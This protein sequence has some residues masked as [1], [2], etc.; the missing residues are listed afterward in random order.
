MARRQEAKDR[1]LERQRRAAAA[2]AA[3]EAK[4]KAAAA[5]GEGDSAVNTAGNDDSAEDDEKYYTI[6]DGG[7]SS[8]EEKGE[9]KSKPAATDGSNGSNA[10]TTKADND[11]KTEGKEDED[12]KPPPPAAPPP[13]EKEKRKIQLRSA[14]DLGN[15]DIYSYHRGRA[16]DE[17]RCPK[18][19]ELLCDTDPLDTNH[20][21]IPPRTTVARIVVRFPLE[22]D[23]D[24]SEDEYV[25]SD[26]EEQQ[27][28]AS[29]GGGAAGGGKSPPPAGSRGKV[30]PNRTLDR[31]DSVGSGGGG[32]RTSRS[33]ASR[34]GAPANPTGGK[35]RR[36]QGGTQQP[37][38]LLPSRNPVPNFVQ[39]I[40]WDLSSPATPAP[41]EYAAR[42]ACE[43]GLSF[44]QTMDLKESIEAFVRSQPQFYAPLI[45]KDPYGT[46]RPDSQYGPPESHCGPV[47]N[48]AAAPVTK[49]VRRGGGGGSS[50]G[51][52]GG[53]LHASG[54]QRKPG[55]VKPDRRGIHVVSPSEVPKAASDVYSAEVCRRAR[56]ASCTIVADRVA[57]NEAT[58]DIVSNEV[59]HICHNRKASG[60]T[61]HCGRH[62]YCDFH[63]AT[64]LSFRVSDYDKKNPLNLPIDYCPVCTLHCTCAKCTRRLEGVAKKLKDTC[65]VQNVGVE[66]VVMDDLFT[67]CSSKLAGGGG[68]G[69][70]SSRKKGSSKKEGSGKKEGSTKKV[71]IDESAS[72][73][74]AAGGAG[75]KGGGSAKRSRLEAEGKDED[76]L[77]PS[78]RSMRSSPSA[79][80]VSSASATASASEPRPKKKR[81]AE[82]Q[83]P[84]VQVLKV[85]PSEFPKE[86]HGTM[87]LDPSSPGDLNQVFTPDGSFP[88]D[89]TAA[90]RVG[91]E[92]EQKKKYQN[93]IPVPAA[94][95][96]FFKCSIC[97]KEKGD[98]WVA[99]MKCPRSY[100][101]KC[102]GG[103]GGSQCKSCEDDQQILPKEEI[104]GGVT[105]I[106][107]KIQKAYA[108]YRD[109]KNT[110]HT[111]SIMIL[112]EL[113]QIL[114][115]LLE[116]EYGGIFAEPVNTQELPDY[117]QTIRKPMDYSTIISKLI[118][119][120]YSP[121]SG[122]ITIDGEKMEPMDEMEEIL[123]FAIMDVDQVHHNCFLYNHKGCQ[124]YRAGE[125]QDRKWHAYSKKY[126]EESIPDKVQ[127]CLTVYHRMLSRERKEKILREEKIRT[128]RHFQ[129]NPEYSKRGKPIA[130]FDPDTKR[131][132]KQY[133]SK[134]S[135]AKAVLMMHA[136]GY[137]SEL[138][139][140]ST[141]AK[142]RLDGAEDPSKPLFGYQW[143][144]TEK[145]RSGNFK[146]KPYFRSDDLVSPT[147]T[148]IAIM[149]VDTVSGVQHRGFESEKSA[150][151]DWLVVKRESYAARL[152]GGDGEDVG[153]RGNECLSDF[154]QNYLD[155]DKSIN[156]IVWNRADPDPNE[157]IVSETPRTSGKMVMEEEHAPM[158]PMKKVK[159]EELPK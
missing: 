44:P 125:V 37:S 151:E 126:T 87:D 65:Q 127:T 81:K 107:K 58:L 135:A 69:G 118:K 132:V 114:R 137:A 82:K 143:V 10:A 25:D 73:T 1:H 19:G 5:G 17:P 33:R 85:R 142:I 74:L 90:Q 50:R 23:V 14:D 45:P 95:G 22:D 91:G 62:T 34:G 144:S 129:S 68:G 75:A 120:G 155:G 121:S 105:S 63:L 24:D 49:V 2:A 31:S 98:E 79:K 97:K 131:I 7:S 150:Y 32:M 123:L 109:S 100:H 47:L 84:P 93:Y 6:L 56:E 12:K 145:L 122:G 136:A 149:K 28:A 55:A 61:F 104:D 148:N 153:A 111:Y 27:G 41:E 18:T 64:R 53:R 99:C 88:V 152:G 29:D 9:E 124:F 154:V 108:K 51:G 40:E 102:L 39:T 106:N 146:V 134:S 92:E 78:S 70:G 66:E 43:F 130:V 80:E 113:L 157:N 71:M 115:K 42:I 94:D 117:L 59:C 38:S 60:I 30:L 54:G 72:A 46:E 147:S 101:K 110:S 8:T 20:Y 138:E 116:Y 52:G 139:L 133:C 159:S 67:L 36:G 128:P 89:S 35:G 16:G 13:Q 21:W 119:G 77:Q 26:L 3:D 57:R 156:G 86:M 140:T 141:N 11:N 48:A 96:N 76:P 83:A 103:V 4:K 158:S 112:S 15:L